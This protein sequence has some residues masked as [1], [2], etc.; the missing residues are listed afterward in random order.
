M[1][2]L[3]WYPLIKDG[4]NQGLDDVDLT[5]VGTVTYTAGKLGN[6]ATFSGSYFKRARFT[7][8]K[9][10]SVAAWVK[11]SETSSVAQ[12]CF[13]QGRDINNDSWRVSFSPN[14]TTMVFCIGNQN[15]S[16]SVTLN[17]WYHVA[18]T[19]DN[20][21]NF[22]F[23]LNGIM[24]KSGTVTTL[25]DYSE[26]GDIMSIGTHYYNNGVGYPLKGQVQDFRYYNH[27]LSE[28]EVKELA[29]G[30][31]LHLPLDWGGNP[32]L[33][34]KSNNQFYWDYST[35]TTTTGILFW[36]SDTMTLET[37][38]DY[39]I[40]FDA[41]IDTT[42]NDLCNGLAVDLFP[43]V[44]PQKNFLFNKETG[45]TNQWKHFTWTTSSTN[46]NMS[47]CYLRFFI[48]FKDSTTGNTVNAPIHVKNIKL[49]KGTK[50]TSWVPPTSS[51]TYSTE[52][53]GL[54]I[55]EDCS[56]YGN[57]GTLG[58]GISSNSSTPKYN[59]STAFTS[60][61]GGITKIP[62]PLRDNA[63]DFSISFWAYINEKTSSKAVYNNRTVV[64]AG[65][66][67]F[68]LSGSAQ[69]RFDDG[70]LQTTFSYAIPVETWT[71]IVVVRSST[72]KKLY[73]NGA[74]QQ[75]VS[76]VGTLTNVAEKGSVG[77]SSASNAGTSTSSNYFNG[78]MS[79]FRLYATA[80][81]ADD[82]KE[83]Y[84]V[85]AQIDKSGNMYCNKLV[86]V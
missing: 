32:N 15:L 39:T 21:A 82:V 83:L 84:Q 70:T 46:E 47:S 11:C 30:L 37:G 81:S 65:I 43:D 28:K 56:G 33:L 6:A 31:C 69:I 22:V 1:S 73:I 23:Y 17:T 35:V 53:F 80:L 86:E 48:D 66:A 61:N 54:K 34:L 29:K 20:D 45:L 16:Y 77:V 2:L 64:G 76:S 14:G 12:Y 26:S 79:D 67:I 5:T 44:L 62:S 42:D 41:K 58:T 74:L 49:E 9:N 10:F 63:T 51:P 60:T 78:S 25:P 59:T 75:T 3:A 36:R 40:S 71:H 50:D 18:M 8:Q 19:I 85:S 13:T 27:A 68:I 57:N 38:V 55:T 52:N 4:I 7:E 24:V 72:D